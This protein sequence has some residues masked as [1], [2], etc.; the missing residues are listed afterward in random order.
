[1]TTYAMPAIGNTVPVGVKLNRQQ[2]HSGLK[3]G[4]VQVVDDGPS[5]WSVDYQVQGNLSD[6]DYNA[7][8]AWLESLKG[9]IHQFEAFVRKYPISYPNGNYPNGFNGRGAVESVNNSE[10]TVKDVPDG[11]A[12]LPGD[13]LTIEGDVDRLHRV[14]VGGEAVSGKL[15]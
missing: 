7:Y 14:A 4:V 11:F 13:F 12:L 5:F 6:K 8:I 10:L 2:R 1:M 9:G 3:G 15:R